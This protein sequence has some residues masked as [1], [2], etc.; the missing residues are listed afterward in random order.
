MSLNTTGLFPERLRPGI[1]SFYGMSYK[2]L[3]KIGERFFTKLSSSKAFEQ[4]VAMAGTGV[5]TE[6]MEGAGF[7]LDTL[8]SGF[9]AQLVH[10]GFGK[11]LI[12]SHELIEDDQYS[13]AIASKVGSCFAK[14]TLKTHEIYMHNVLNNGFSTVSAGMYNNADAKALFAT[15]HPLL[16]GGTFSNKPTT[17]GDLSELTIENLIIQMRNQTDHAGIRID[18]QP[19]QLIVSTADEFNAKRLTMSDLTTGSGNNDINTIKTLGLELIVSPYLTDNDAWFITTSENTDGEG[20]VM[21]EREGMK[22]ASDLDTNTMNV[23]YTMYTRFSVGYVSPF[24]IF[25][26][27]GA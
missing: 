3:P 16:K 25:G 12:F 9:A 21:F 19:R 17:D 1:Y 20:L 8:Q 4:M 18:L 14:S 23:S 24:C 22:L 7:A 15:D 10:K 26:S 5:L 27:S 11:K 13:P 2:D 6:K